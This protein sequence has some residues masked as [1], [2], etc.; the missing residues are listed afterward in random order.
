MQWRKEELVSTL[1]ACEVRKG[2]IAPFALGRDRRAWTFRAR[3]GSSEFPSGL[4]DFEEHD[5]QC[6][7]SIVPKV[8]VLETLLAVSAVL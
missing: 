5:L 2:R 4:L 6:A 7:G 3:S 8:L 1:S